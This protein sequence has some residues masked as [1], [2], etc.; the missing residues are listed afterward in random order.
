MRG[1]LTVETTHRAI[2]YRM[3]GD[4]ALR[5]MAA[6]HGGEDATW[7]DRIDP[8]VSS[9]FAGWLTFSTEPVVSLRWEIDLERTSTALLR[10]LANAGTAEVADVEAALRAWRTISDLVG[11]TE[12]RP[13]GDADAP[14][15]PDGDLSGDLVP[16]GRPVR[17]LPRRAGVTLLP[18]RL[19]VGR[20]RRDHRTGRG[21]AP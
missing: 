1:T 19:G 16:C 17:G 11:I 3:D 2:P 13:G 8:F 10:V 6:F 18:G 7:V 15:G 12:A 9:A 5:V 4:S 21:G 14:T 20:A